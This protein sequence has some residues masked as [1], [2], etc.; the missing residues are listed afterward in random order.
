MSLL[1]FTKFVLFTS[2]PPTAGPLTKAHPSGVHAPNSGQIRVMGF[3]VKTKNI[4][5]PQLD[6]L[7]SAQSSMIL[8]NVC[9]TLERFSS[10]TVISNVIDLQ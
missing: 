3:G 8:M 9:Y 5:T 10:K 2:R 1:I 6:F 4:P 7:N